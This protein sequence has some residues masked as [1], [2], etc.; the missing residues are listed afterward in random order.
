MR[1]VKLQTKSPNPE[2]F[3]W[4]GG[5]GSRGQGRGTGVGRRVG[6][7]TLISDALYDPYTYLYIL[8]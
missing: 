2:F 1:L 3:F 7:I 5:G 4:G 8:L 6:T